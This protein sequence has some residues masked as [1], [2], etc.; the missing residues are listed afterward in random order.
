VRVSLIETGLN[1]SRETFE[2]RVAATFRWMDAFM[3]VATLAVCALGAVACYSYVPLLD[4]TPSEGM[5]VRLQLSDSG[6]TTLSGYLGRH[7]T[8]IRGRVTSADRGEIHLSV[9]DV[10]AADGSEQFWQGDPVTIARALV[11]TTEMQRL[12]KAQ[13]VGAAGAI[14]TLV[15][16]IAKRFGLAGTSDRAPTGPGGPAR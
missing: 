15:V 5:K 2:F 16:V 11:A 10:E 1:A 8:A 6:S 9:S 4:V 14:V 12:A 7:V 3:R 13:T